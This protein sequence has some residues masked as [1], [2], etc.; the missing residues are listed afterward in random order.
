MCTQGKSH[1]KK[2]RDQETQKFF[3]ED[4]NVT[5]AN[6]AIFETHIRGKQHAKKREQGEDRV[7]GDMNVKLTILFSISKKCYALKHET[8]LK[9]MGRKNLFQTEENF[10]CFIRANA[11]VMCVSN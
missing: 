7:E 4:C 9:L 6:Q 10:Q 3:C 11:N 2:V 5:C 8:F 1:R